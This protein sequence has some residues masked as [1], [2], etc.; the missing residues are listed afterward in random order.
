MFRLLLPSSVLAREREAEL[1]Q[2]RV[3]VFVVGGAR[4]DRDVE[5]ANRC[6]LVVIYL[7]EDDLLADTERIVA[8]PVEGTQAQAAEVADS[9]Q[10]DRDQAVEEV[11]HPRAAQRDARADRHPLADLEPGDRLAGAAH[12]RALAR[13]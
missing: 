10:R 13:D 6:D 4:R 11:P 12:L 5:A 8:A 7:G 3:G 9:R 1:A 2:Q